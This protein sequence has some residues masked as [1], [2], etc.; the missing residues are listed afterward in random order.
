METTEPR[1]P[2][3]KTEAEFDTRKELTQ[4]LL[5]DCPIPRKEL[6]SQLPLFLQRQQLS[7]IL[8]LHEIYKQIL[9][10]HGVIMEFGIRWGPQQVVMQMMR[11]IYEPYNYTRKVIGFDTFAGFVDVAPKDGVSENVQAGDLSVTS[12]YQ[13]Y[14]AKILT[15]HERGSPISH[16]QKWELVAGDVRVT[17]PEYLKKHPE[18]IIALAYIDVDLYDPTK[19]ILEQ[20]QPYLT[21]GSIIVFDE[22]MHR[23]YI[24]E[25]VA[26]RDVL[27]LDR[28]RIK[29]WPHHSLPSYAV[30]E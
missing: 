3:R 10:V 29:R 4:L 5:D 18:T 26:V 25:T 1:V 24:G 20:I 28:Y 17:L 23:D 15:L 11:G 19:V 22:L 6:L 16:I 9:D 7:R 30:V 14:L 12:N 21:K 27:G 2:L 13:E 8:F